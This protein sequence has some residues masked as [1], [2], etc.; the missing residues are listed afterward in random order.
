[1]ELFWEYLAIPLVVAVVAIVLSH[2]VQN[3]SLK[4]RIGAWLAIAA[5]ACFVAIY[6]LNVDR[7]T[8]VFFV[9]L[10]SIIVGAVALQSDRRHERI[11]QLEQEVGRLRGK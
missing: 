7:D 11:R 6:S 9:G 3:Q 10:C 5:G 2:S 1:M 8:F 4:L